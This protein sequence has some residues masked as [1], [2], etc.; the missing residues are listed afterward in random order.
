MFLACVQT[1]LVYLKAHYLSCIQN[2]FSGETHRDIKINVMSF[3]SLWENYFEFNSTNLL[4]SKPV[5]SVQRLGVPN[6]LLCVICSS[7]LESA[8][9]PFSFS[10]SPFRCDLFQYAVV[11]TCNL[12]FPLFIHVIYL[13]NSIFELC[14]LSDYSIF[15]RVL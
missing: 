13:L 1:R 6:F 15:Y 12:P 9:F 14:F 10:S 11:H 3:I 5:E 2:P 7:S 4:S 8:S